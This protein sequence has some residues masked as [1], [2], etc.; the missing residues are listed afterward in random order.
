M[1]FAQL[2]SQSSSLTYSNRQSQYGCARLN[3]KMWVVHC[4][5]QL[6]KAVNDELKETA[7]EEVSPMRRI[8]INL[9]FFF[10]F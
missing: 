10:V 1:S 5:Q 9:L 6:I 7:K 3:E 4:R 2:I 8:D